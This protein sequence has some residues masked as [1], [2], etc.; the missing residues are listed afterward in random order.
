MQPDHYRISVSPDGGYVVANRIVPP[1]TGREMRTYI[2]RMADRSGVRL[3]AGQPHWASQRAWR[4]IGPRTVISSDGW[5]V[6]VA[7]IKT[8]P[9]ISMRKVLTVK[10]ITLAGGAPA[11][12]AAL[13]PSPDGKLAVVASGIAGSAEW[14]LRFVDIDNTRPL[15]LTVR[16]AQN[17]WWQ[18]NTEVG[19]VGHRGIRRIVCVVEEAR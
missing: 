6:L 1:D 12:D 4:W 16:R 9:S 7:R 14:D 13:L 11:N 5:L 15:E 18:S 10:T 17:Y 2:V 19:Y 3:D 8:D